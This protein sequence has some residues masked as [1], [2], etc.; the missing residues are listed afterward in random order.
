MK[1]QF[2]SKSGLQFLGALLLLGGACLVEAGI[3]TTKHNLS[4][5]SGNPTRAT[6]EQ[7]MCLM[8]HAPHS[9][10]PAGPLWNHKLSGATYTPYSSTTLNAAPGQPTGAS[11]LCLACHDGTIAVGALLNMPGAI[12]G[13]SYGTPFYDGTILGLEGTITGAANLGVDLRDDHPISFVYDVALAGYSLELN[14][15]A[16][17]TDKVRLDGNDEMQCTSCHDPHTDEFPKF[18]RMGFTDGSGFGSP[19]CIECHN[20]DGWESDN[21][22]RESLAEWDGL[23]DNPWHIDGQNVAGDQVAGGSTSTPKANGCESCHQP[24]SNVNGNER[25]LKA[26]GES[27]ICMTCHN[28]NVSDAA[29]P[30]YNM[31]TYFDRTYTHMSLHA[32]YDGKHTPTRDPVNYN[33]RETSY[34]SESG[35]TSILDDFRHAECQDC[36]NPHYAKEGVS[37]NPDADIDVA[38]SNQGSSGGTTM[39]ISPVL[40]G[41]WG[42]APTWPAN[43]G[44]VTSYS[45]VEGVN[46][47]YQYEL[48]LKCHSYYAFGDD[49]PVEPHNVYSTEYGAP[50]D[51]LTDQAKE[52]NPNNG[53]YHPVAAA[54]KNTFT[55]SNATTGCSGT[56]WACDYSAAL[57]DNLTPDSTMSCS[58][59]HTAPESNTPAAPTVEKDGPKGPHG[60]N[61]W[62]I[63][64]EDYD[65]TTGQNGTEGHLC[66]KCHD[67][68]VY[69]F[70]AAAADWWKTGFSDHALGKNLHARHVQLRDM[71]CM[72]CH[73]GVPHG[74]DKR[75][76]LIFGKGTPDLPPY[77]AH[78]RFPQD[79]DGDLIDE[80]YGID[81][82]VPVDTIESGNWVKSD[83]HS[84]AGGPGVGDC[85]NS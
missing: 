75:A 49:P 65:E 19:L 77:N 45:E 39:D 69:G 10:D 17:L 80:P 62:P 54:G 67:P 32:S 9:A 79:A 53:S 43:W 73:S 37:P 28:G 41:G 83:C 42:V 59:C 8:C 7:R 78:D 38:W 58:D 52:F 82:S 12:Q 46:F 44:D 72:A 84:N 34:D 81:S 21:K 13:Y 70:P 56:A 16:G 63:L 60:S 5:T 57:L 61:V 14:D 29:D 55:M 47:K 74:S 4:S 71:P 20:K 48:C 31:Q 27:E 26:D 40:E 64:Y 11:K 50:Y 18:L 68:N 30:T 23:G 85:A 35:G 1:M 66:F 76:L 33:I 6:T 51:V 2:Y 25:L 36:H 15:P 22:H 24:H 3:A